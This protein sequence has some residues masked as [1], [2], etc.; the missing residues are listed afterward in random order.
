MVSISNSFSIVI[1]TYNRADFIGLALKSVLNQTFQNFEVIIIDNNSTDDTLE[2]IKGFNDNRINVF[3]INNNGVIG[4]S[5]NKGIKIAKGD[6]IAFLDS[7][8]L[9]YPDRLKIIKKHIHNNPSYDVISTNEYM[10]D[11]NS[12]ILSNLMY[13]PIEKNQYQ[14]LLLY[15]NRLS[16]S[17]TVVR[18]DFLIKESILFS[19]SKDLIT[20]EDYDFWLRLSL[21]KAKFFFI[22]SFQGEYLVHE[23]NLSSFMKLHKANLSN[24]YRDHIFNIQNFEKDRN[25]LWFKIKYS[26]IFLDELRYLITEKRL[27]NILNLTSSFIKSPFFILKIITKKIYFKSINILRTIIYN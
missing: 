13:G 11:K 18:K 4:T 27:N 22:P 25:L 8:D 10:V 17:A 1:P 20:V 5:R 19:E 23:T 7:D 12:K 16:P 9:W 15:G 14:S 2:V 3:N 26:S 6:W 24:L 21:K